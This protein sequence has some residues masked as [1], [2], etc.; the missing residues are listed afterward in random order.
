MSHNQKKLGLYVV[1]KLSIKCKINPFH[2]YILKETNDQNLS[3]SLSKWESESTLKKIQF[4]NSL[5]T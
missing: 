4:T 5:L 2:N 3:P 1:G